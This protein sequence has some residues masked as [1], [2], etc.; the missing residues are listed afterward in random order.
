MLRNEP[1]HQQND[2]ESRAV[3]S[4]LAMGASLSTPSPVRAL[5][6]QFDRLQL[7]SKDKDDVEKENAEPVK[8]NIQQTI[9]T[10]PTPTTI[11][12][13]DLI[14]KPAAIVAE[15]PPKP[16]EKEQP[17][18]PEINDL[19]AP[20]P[21]PK[22]SDMR[23]GEDFAKLL[24]SV[25]SRLQASIKQVLSELE[26]V[27]AIPEEAASSIRIAAGKAQ[28]L[29]RK[30]LSKFDELVKKNLNP[31]DGDPQPATLDDLE[32]YWALVEIELQDIDECFEK[33][34]AWRANGWQAKEPTETEQSIPEANNNNN[35]T[36]KKT[37]PVRPVTVVDPET[38]AKQ[39]EKQ[40]AAAEMRRKALAEA[41]QKA[42][43]AQQAQQKK[44][45]SDKDAAAASPDVLMVL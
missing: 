33:V 4:P 28:L 36:K 34:N 19:K 24:E 27:E 43:A 26:E 45:A 21:A 29:V 42:R 15:S 3:R 2:K 22:K 38:R 16:E 17:S 12:K 37:T 11:F 44:A 31:V 14:D 9:V 39:A 40:K 35:I 23:T 5:I 30:K 20:S 25:R 7:C 41:K 10:Q 18:P 32:G 6:G 1:V 13:S 8:Q